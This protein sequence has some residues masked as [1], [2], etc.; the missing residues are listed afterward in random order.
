[1]KASVFH[2]REIL[3]SPSFYKK[4][5]A[6][7]LPVMAQSLIQSMVSLI[8]NFMVAGLGDIKMSGVNIAG[9]INFVFLIFLSSLCISG[10]IFMSQYNGA[11]DS[12]GMKQSFRFKIVVTVF[13]SALYTIFCYVN[14]RPVLSFM[15][16]GNT[17]S[18]E[19][20]AEAAVYMRIA[21]FTWIPM[22]LSMSA[23]TSLREIGKVRQPLVFSVIATLI[24]TFFNW[25]FIYG[26]LGAPRLEA[27]GAAY[28]TIIAR[29]CEALLFI[30]YLR[31][32]QPPFYSRLCRIF[33]IRLSLFL[34]ILSKSGMILASDMSWILTESVVTALYNSRGGAE[35][36]SGMSAG[37]TIANLFFICFGGIHTSV[38]VIMG[39]T[40]GSGD[41]KKA[42]M[43]KNWLLSGSFVFG[44]F[45]GITGSFTTFLI[46][47]VFANLS[48]E[49]QIVTRSMV[50]M[51]AAYMP[52]WAYLNGQFAV[53]RT[54]G[55]AL[56][57][58]ITDVTT[59]LFLV[60]PGMY[61]LTYYTALGPVAMYGLIKTTDWIK[62]TIAALWLKKEYWLKNLAQSGTA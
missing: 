51:N 9:Q 43:Q 44:L 15:V 46:P 28:A 39:S 45:M 24:N 7:S 60:L 20:V 56:M 13:F 21:A 57:G 52:L 30:L 14:P 50:L 18:A 26:N 41:L 42:R 49:A 27:A 22:A 48:A 38:T 19:I 40:L 33:K 23:G 8:D 59:N 12:E 61:V 1:M 35:I 53:S 29:S 2:K 17:Q 5:L 3:G 10:G 11:K 4:A 55:D 37:F 16:H 36:V 31:T 6:L 32:K 54:G 58:V 25:I 62:T 47:L 34:S